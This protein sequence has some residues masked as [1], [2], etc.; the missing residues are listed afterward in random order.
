M[1]KYVLWFIN[2]EGLLDYSIFCPTWVSF[3]VHLGALFQYFGHFLLLYHG[4]YLLRDFNVSDYFFQILEHCLYALKWLNSTKILYM[5]RY[6]ET[7][8]PTGQHLHFQSS[9]GAKTE[10]AD[11]YVSN[12]YISGS[13]E[14]QHGKLLKLLKPA[15]KCGSMLAL[16]FLICINRFDLPC[17]NLKIK[18]FIW[19]VRKFGMI[20]SIKS[21]VLVCFVKV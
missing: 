20:S 1:C 16:S 6:H 3:L 18:Y 2:W 12:I 14:L 4:G 17:F 10:N 7:D 9:N 11:I 19:G 15:H 8:G 21:I 13:L 5:Q